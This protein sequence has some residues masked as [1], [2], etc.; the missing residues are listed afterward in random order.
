MSRAIQ[1]ATSATDGAEG[2]SETI[3][4][5]CDD[6]SVW[7]FDL[8]ADRRAGNMEEERP[9]WRLLPPIPDTEAYHLDISETHAARERQR[10]KQL[11]ARVA[12][13]E[14]ALPVSK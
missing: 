5:L 7:E 12:E 10:V 1:I 3:V 11:E 8:M 13:L 2:C 6:G 4:A 9:D 14:A